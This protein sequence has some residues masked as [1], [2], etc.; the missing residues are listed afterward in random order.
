MEKQEHIIE[1]IKT[2]LGHIGVPFTSVA[3]EHDERIKSYRFMIITPDSAILIG[4]NGTRLLALNHLVKRMITRGEDE[5]SASFMIDV[6]DYQKKRM[7][8]IRA[9]AHMLAERAR[10]F[11]SSVEM[12]PMSSYERMLVHAEFTDTPD[13]ATESIGYGRDR[14]VVIKHTESKNSSSAVFA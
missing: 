3:V 14:K 6:N 4:E 1:T 11:K 9:K 8:D 13:I 12:E 5:A 2:L 7:D 10:Y